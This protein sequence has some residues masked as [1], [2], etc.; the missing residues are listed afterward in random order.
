MQAASD[1]LTAFVF[2]LIVATVAGSLILWPV[3]IYKTLF[4]VSV[5]SPDDVRNTLLAV[6]ALI[7][8]PFLI[9]R[10]LIAAK[11]T[12]ISR[13]GHYTT[14]FTK[15]VEQL[16]ADKVV[17]KREFK[18]LYAKS[19]DG[20]VQRDPNGDPIPEL[21]ENGEVAGEYASYEVTTTNYE[22]R[23]GAIYALERI[24]QDSERDAWPIYLTLCSYV[25]NNAQPRIKDLASPGTALRNN[26]DIEEIFNVLDRYNGQMDVDASAYFEK[27]HIPDLR[28]LSGRFRRAHFAGCSIA[29]VT[30]RGGI[31]VVS[32]VE[33]KVGYLDIR[34]ADVWAISLK[35]SNISNVTL[36]DC[37][38]RQCDF[39]METGKQLW[40]LSSDVTNCVVSFDFTDFR[41]SQCTLKSVRIES[42]ES[43]FS[44]D[45]RIIRQSRF[46]ECRFVEVDF[47][48]VDVGSCEFVSCI[49]ERC[50][51]VSMAG[52]TVEGN[53]FI[54]CFT[55]NDFQ[56]DVNAKYPDVDFVSQW[57]TWR[58]SHRPV[59]YYDQNL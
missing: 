25:Q 57:S 16:G 31:E 28:L 5:G 18:P 7:G 13:E 44:R 40:L 29:S 43:W 3:L 11:Q 10:T 12:N 54:E 22:V 50:N 58:T 19:A 36:N 42:K 59:G 49:F 27:I 53:T 52:L 32:L 2:V 24:A 48:G 46:E 47:S 39:G 37:S 26:S 34:Q 41:V 35:R 56:P 14:L 9:W 21:L 8:V 45:I 4:Y 51:L 23:L 55:D 33:C 1:I 15:A 38:V 30:V 20:K 17:K 6:A